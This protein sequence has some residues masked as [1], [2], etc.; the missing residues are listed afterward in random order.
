VST[1]SIA[2]RG[3]DLIATAGWPGCGIRCGVAR[4]GA[5]SNQ[6]QARVATA[7]PVPAD[8]LA[9]QRQAVGLR[10]QPA[11]VSSRDGTP[12]EA[13]QRFLEGDAPLP[14]RCKA[15]QNPDLDADFMRRIVRAAEDEGRLSAY[16]TY[17]GLANL[18]D[19]PS[20]PADVL[21]L[22]ED[23]AL[24]TSRSTRYDKSWRGRG[25]DLPE[26]YIWESLL[27]KV[28]SR[29]GQATDMAPEDAPAHP[30]EEVRR[31]IASLPD[32]PVPVIVTLAQDPQARVRE[33]AA[34]NPSCPP[35]TLRQLDRDDSPNV[36][37]AALNNS[38]W[39]CS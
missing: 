2:G 7:I 5:G 10:S 3:F 33:S 11:R 26:D 24:A 34:W 1:Q 14:L 16:V 29:L 30:V 27:D 31:G 12:A 22:I 35:E 32:T 4:N 17:D 21:R 20:A 9:Q 19:N 39:S 28:R 6:Y 37:W 13:L 8:L 25:W 15:L 36:R 18:A 23:M 38:N